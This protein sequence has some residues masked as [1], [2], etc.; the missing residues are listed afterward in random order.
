M[1]SG[2]WCGIFL[3]RAGRFR[4]AENHLD[5]V[6]I[7]IGL[8]GYLPQGFSLPQ[9]TL[10]PAMRRVCAGG[11]FPLF[12]ARLCGLR[13]H[14][15]PRKTE[16]SPHRIR[17]RIFPQ[18]RHRQ[19]EQPVYG[20]GAFARFA[21]KIRIRMCVFR[22]RALCRGKRHHLLRGAVPRGEPFGENIC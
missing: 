1:R 5:M 13:N 21:Q 9:G 18:R 17:R 2:R 12:P 20:C 10:K 7:G 3:R 6:R 11:V 8:Y 19:R 4:G 22:C 16:R 14:A 15:R